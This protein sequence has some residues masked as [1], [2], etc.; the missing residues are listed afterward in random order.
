MI[1]EIGLVA[2]Y[3]S[4]NVFSNESFSFKGGSMRSYHLIRSNIEIKSL[5]KQNM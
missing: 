4:S 1:N 2:C 3:C 5:T